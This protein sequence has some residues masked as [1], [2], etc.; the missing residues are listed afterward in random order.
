MKAPAID[1]LIVPESCDLRGA[2]VAIDQNSQGVVF[3]CDSERRLLGAISDG[4]ARRAIV[5]GHSLETPVGAVMN[6]QCVSCPVGAS[7]EDLLLRLS[8]VGVRH[9]PIVDEQQRIV[10]IAAAT[11]LR[12]IQV[13]SPD[14]QGNELLYVAECVKTGWVSSQGRFI[15]EFEGLVADFCGVPHGVAVSNGTVALHL[16]LAALGIG[17]GDEVIVPDFTFA[18]TASAVIHAGATPVLVDVDPR[19]WTLDVAATHAAVTPRTRALIPVHLYGQPCEMDALLD[20]ARRHNLRVVEDCAEALGSRYRDRQ[21]GSLGDAAAFSFYGNKTV[22]TG[23]GGM[24]LFAEA[25]VAERARRL[26]DHGMSPARRYWHDEVGFNFRMTNL[27]AALG[28]AQMERVADFLE[29]KRQLSRAYDQGLAGLP[30]LSRREPVAWADSVC[31]LYTCLVDPGAQLSRDELIDKLYRNG[32]ESR[33]VFCPLHE[34]PPYRAFANGQDL[35]VSSSLARRGISLPSAVNLTAREID[36]VV[37][38]VRRILG[39]RLMV[40]DP[41]RPGAS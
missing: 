41:A 35:P 8:Q 10:D 21:V 7:P 5:A 37:A 1:D 11:R 40:P 13:A 29:R 19:T 20:V 2:L 24:V 15:R 22:T 9:V 16:A 32:I 31:W 27:Q 14:L 33:P 6:R 39:V 34:M 12:R 30:G 18:A 17:A 23:E 38:A 25:A 28:V 4:D 3:V 26:R 36:D